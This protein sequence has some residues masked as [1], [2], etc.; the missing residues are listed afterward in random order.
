[1]FGKIL[2]A[3]PSIH[4]TE[5]NKLY[6]FKTNAEKSALSST[7]YSLLNELLERDFGI[8]NAKI[9]K[10]N[11]GKP[12]LEGNDNIHFNI[13]HTQGA[14]AIAFCDSET[15]VDIEHE[16]PINPKIAGRHFCDDEMIVVEKSNNTNAELLKMW[17]RKEAYIKMSGEG[18]SSGLNTFN[19]LD[20]KIAKKIKTFE[21]EGFYI[22]VC[23]EKE[24]DFEIIIKTI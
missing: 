5:M 6:I 24:C 3:A 13:S 21:I 10:T 17:T 4:P 23:S 16:R 14:V 22:S 11:K 15:G 1:M 12:Y 19:T 9:L 7:A 18:L 2:K 20:E 8:K